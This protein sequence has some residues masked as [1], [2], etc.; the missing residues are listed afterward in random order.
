MKGIILAGG[1]GSRLYP[2][3]GVMSKQL[4]PVYDKPMI[5]YPLSTLMLA[6]IRDIL[7]ISTPEH[8]PIF[9]TLLDDGE[10][11]G[12]KL[13]YAEQAEPR[14]LAEAFLIGREF[15]SGQPCALVLGDNLFYGHGLGA[16]LRSAATLDEGAVVFGYRV[17]DP[18]RYGVVEFDG[19]GQV[20]SI[21]EKP[22]VPKSN[23]AVVGLYFYD[24]TVVEKA[25]L[26]RPSDR[27]EL[28]ITDL[29]NA[30]L[31]QEKLR[32]QLMGR[33]FT[34]L[35]TG[36][37]EAMLEASSLVGTIEKRQGVKIACPEEIALD[38][39][40][41]TLEQ[42]CE[43]V[44]RLPKCGYKEYLLGVEGKVPTA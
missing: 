32:V 33:G 40:F 19:K 21:E 41:I 7:I 18:K 1:H 15:I 24:A 23:Y 36:T 28:E 35:D 6:G 44:E 29:N 4:M 27:G 42:F 43:G 37:P 13:T 10:Q 39:K 25:S 30:Y 20:V 22:T 14:G 5:Y 38:M 11:W 17:S 3:T 26:I 12:I 16:I 8:L 34:W 9:K 31:E 2:M